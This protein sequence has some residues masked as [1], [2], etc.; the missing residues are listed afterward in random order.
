ME[1]P[2]ASLLFLG[3]CL[4]LVMSISSRGVNASTCEMVPVNIY[5]SSGSGLDPCRIACQTK[6]VD[7]FVIS[8]LEMGTYGLGSCTCCHN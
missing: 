1:K 2:A 6:F 7:A 5:S 4:V 8:K 3:F